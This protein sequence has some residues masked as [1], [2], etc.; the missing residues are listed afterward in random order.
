MTS[1]N[2]KKTGR[3]GEGTGEGGGKRRGGGRGVGKGREEKRY[4]LSLV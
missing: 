1:E 3:E 2:K 4:G